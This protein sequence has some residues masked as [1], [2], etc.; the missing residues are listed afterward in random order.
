MLLY[1]MGRA[2][3]ITQWDKSFLIT[4]T[5]HASCSVALPLLLVAIG[6]AAQSSPWWVFCDNE[7]FLNARKTQRAY[8]DAGVNLWQIPP[9]SPDLNPV[10]KSW[11]WLRRKLRALDLKVAV[12]KRPVLGKM[13]Y[14]RRVRSVCSS[15]QAQRVAK[16]CARGLRKVCEEVVRNKGAATRG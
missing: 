2:P 14:K 3:K 9:R 1:R 10:E 12:A 15:Q 16:A 6:C 4:A 13:A 8:R 5:R 7:T 11:S